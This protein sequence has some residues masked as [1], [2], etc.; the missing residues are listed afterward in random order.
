[1]KFPIIIKLPDDEDPSTRRKALVVSLIYAACYAGALWYS[2][3]VVEEL[4]R[5][6]YRVRG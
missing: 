2:F 4:L 6:L 3:K 1:M 5:W